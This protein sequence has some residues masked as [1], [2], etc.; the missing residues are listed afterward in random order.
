MAMPTLLAGAVA[1]CLATAPMT[2]AMTA[3][4]RLLP[5]AERYPLPPSEITAEV[6]KEAGLDGRIDERQHIALTLLTHFGFGATAG[7]IYGMLARRVNSPPAL[8]G[9]GFAMLVWTVSYLGLLPAFGILR[10]ATEHPARRNALMI[11][12]HVIWGAVTGVLT[13]RFQR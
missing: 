9:I 3:M 13:A 7:G 5:R 1:G 11:V 12:A 4:H 6:S 2:L 10:P 8:G